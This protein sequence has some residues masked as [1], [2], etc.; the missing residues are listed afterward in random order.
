MKKLKKL[1]NK[2]E[3]LVSILVTMVMIFI[4]TLIVL[5][6][7]RITHREQQ[8]ALD[9]QLSSQAFYAAESGV[10]D[11][12]EALRVGDWQPYDQKTDC[13]PVEGYDNV[14]DGVDGAISYSCLLIDPTP[15]SLEYGNIGVGEARVVPVNPEGV[16]NVGEATIYWGSAD[17]DNAL[18]G[19]P[20]GT[21]NQ[22]PQ[23]WFADCA[24]AV[25]RFDIVPTG[26]ANLQRSSLV[27]N[28][29]TVFALPMSSGGTNS[30]NVSQ[31]SGGNQGA[32]VGVNCDPEGTPQHCRLTIE[33]LNQGSEYHLRITALYKAASMTICSPD[34]GSGA[35][36]LLN[37]QALVDATGR[38]ND[39]LRRIQVRVNSSTIEGPV[40]SYAIESNQTICKQFSVIPGDSVLNIGSDPACNID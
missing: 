24:P 31:A 25:L 5:S 21:E 34:C 2:Q 35:H 17:G 27:T 38:A 29:A 26:A 36:R 14:L 13:D 8:Q 22:F 1:H 3:G 7:S 11:A 10:N 23:E 20:S 33:G 32:T 6:F 9:R 12:V 39:V 40:P 18:T 16:G 28:T 15:H 37:A 19:C 30:I 4:L